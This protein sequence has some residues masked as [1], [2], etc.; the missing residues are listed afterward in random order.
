MQD[1]LWLRKIPDPLDPLSMGRE[2]SLTPLSSVAL[3]LD[4][5]GCDNSCSLHSWEDEKN[6]VISKK[7]PN[8][9]RVAFTDFI[10]KTD[11]CTFHVL[12]LQ[13]FSTFLSARFNFL[14]GL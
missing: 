3:E 5:G 12:I 4:S 8:W 1:V 13:M 11:F 10:I 14:I 7:S 9:K 6:D 2:P